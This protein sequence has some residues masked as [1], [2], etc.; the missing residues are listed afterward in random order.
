M[1]NKLPSGSRRED[2]GAKG[3][4]GGGVLGEVIIDCQKTPEVGIRLF[5]AYTPKHP[6]FLVKTEARPRRTN[7]E[8]RPSRGNTA[9]RDGL[10]TEV[11]RPSSTSRLVL[12]SSVYY[13]FVCRH[14]FKRGA[15]WFTCSW[16]TTVCAEDGSIAVWISAE[17]SCK[18]TAIRHSRKYKGAT[19][20]LFHRRVNARKLQYVIRQKFS[21]QVPIISLLA[22]GNGVKK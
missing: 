2:R 6:C 7:S 12:C 1:P 19:I 11:S 15:D 8:A 14:N 13:L 5:P 9:P 10:E 21:P 22:A 20:C 16:R 17:V 3:A 18:T 4:E